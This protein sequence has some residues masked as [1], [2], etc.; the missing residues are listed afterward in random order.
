MHLIKFLDHY[1]YLFRICLKYKENPSDV[2]V[3]VKTP[4]GH[5]CLYGTSL[6]TGRKNRSHYYPFDLNHHGFI[7]AGFYFP[8]CCGLDMV[9][10]RGSQGCNCVYPIKLD[11][12][13]INVSSSP[14]WS[15]FVE[16]FA[17]QLGLL[18]I[19]INPVNF[20]VL[21]LSN[22]NISLDITP[23]TGISF[24]ASEVS[25]INSSLSMHKVQLD[26]KLVGDY[27]LLNITWFKPLA[28]SQGKTY[29]PFSL[30]VSLSI[31][32]AYFLVLRLAKLLNC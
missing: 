11:I 19:Q 18:S 4:K 10:K 12:L 22:W 30:V 28:P 25:A 24:S 15:L 26:P 8:D 27:K 9:L 29:L 14:N 13:L 5:K 32:M 1:Y 21:T 16:E 7:N 6:V 31:A 20:Y 17:S 3:L 2:P 23:N